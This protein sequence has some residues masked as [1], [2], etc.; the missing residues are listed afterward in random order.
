MKAENINSAEKL[1]S[2]N[3]TASFLTSGS[4]M[5]PLLRTHKDI[6]TVKRAETPLR[7]DDVPLYKKEGRENLVLHR[8]IGITNDGI[9]IMRG[10]NTYRK[11]YVKPCDVVGVMVSIYRNGKYIDCLKSKGYKIYVKITKFFYPV[12]WFWHI[13]VRPVLGNFKRKILKLK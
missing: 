5:Y 3:E 4:S 13:A 2:E 11:E 9:Y 10:D 7:V 8:I 1:L 12:R 6:V